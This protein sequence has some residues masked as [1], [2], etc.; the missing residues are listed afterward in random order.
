MSK[1]RTWIVVLFIVA[2]LSTRLMGMHLHLCFDG[3]EPPLSLQSQTNEIADTL[4]DVT[5]ADLQSAGPV[6]QDVDIDL[7]GSALGK[8]VKAG[9][10]LPVLLVAFSLLFLAR[11]PV[12][13]QPRPGAVPLVRSS[14]PRIRPPLRA[15]PR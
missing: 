3:T 9:F 14:R 4:D 1:F 13:P 15:P 8:L 6:L 2:F 5:R 12:V 10:D 7:I 11:S